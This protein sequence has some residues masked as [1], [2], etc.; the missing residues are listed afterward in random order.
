[1]A[2]YLALTL[3]FHLAPENKL[4]CSWNISPYHTLTH[5]ISTIYL[6]VLPHAVLRKL[7]NVSAHAREGYS[8]PFVCQLV[9]WSVS[10]S[11]SQSFCHMNLEDGSLPK[12][13]TSIKKLHWPF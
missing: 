10:Q 11:V 3:Y 5:V 6:I 13:E 2:R 1:M 9:S 12:I 4:A 7:I 8:A